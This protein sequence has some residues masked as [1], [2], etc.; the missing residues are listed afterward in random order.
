VASGFT[1]YRY[2]SGDV[3]RFLIAE[4]E[5]WLCRVAPLRLSFGD[6]QVVR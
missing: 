1:P 6:H 2:T 4:N 3:K 5:F